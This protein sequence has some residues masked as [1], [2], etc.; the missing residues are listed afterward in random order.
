[1]NDDA[2][3][4]ESEDPIVS[5]QRNF[6]AVWKPIIGFGILFGFGVQPVLPFVSPLTVLGW[7]VCM[8]L[9][10]LVAFHTFVND[11]A[12][13]KVEQ[14]ACIILGLTIL[15]FTI[16]GIKQVWSTTQQL[17]QPCTRL[18]MIMLKAP[19]SQAADTY[20]ALHCP[21]YFVGTWQP[22]WTKK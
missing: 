10:Y 17:S 7:V 21:L 8:G 22:I 14:F 11:Y 13:N 19:N 15:L 9:F 12:L 20:T 16:A 1:M 2:N 6:E 4:T 18:R 5:G 3:V